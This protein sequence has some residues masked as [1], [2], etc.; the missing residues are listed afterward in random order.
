VVCSRDAAD[1]TPILSG[2]V[3]P[4]TLGARRLFVGKGASEAVAVPQAKQV[5]AGRA[6]GTMDNDRKLPVGITP[7]AVAQRQEQPVEAGNR[8]S[9]IARHLAEVLLVGRLATCGSTVHF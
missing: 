5:N 4:R 1:I 7:P 6:S 8:R 9:R 3:R 2:G